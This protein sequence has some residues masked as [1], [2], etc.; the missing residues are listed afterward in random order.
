MMVAPFRFD[1]RTDRIFFCS[2]VLLL[3]ATLMTLFLPSA[4]I[5]AGETNHRLIP[6]YVAV[7]TNLIHIARDYCRDGNDWKEIARI[8]KL[9]EPYLIYHNSNIQVPLSMLVTEPLS[10]RVA[11]VN[12]SVSLLG[13][14]EQTIP[15]RKD[16]TLAAGQTVIS[17]PDGYTH[18]ILPDNTYT[19]IEPD[20]RFTINYLF[21]LPDGN[22]KTDF[23]LKKGNIV[24]WMRQKLR[25]NDSFQT[26]TPIAVTGIRGTEY[27]LK[28]DDS[29]AN[30]V[31]TLSGVVQVS[32]ASRTIALEAGKGTRVRKGAPPE[33]PRLLPDPPEGILIERL[34]RTL[35]IQI[36]A[37]ARGKAKTIHLRITTDEQGQQTVFAQN[38]APGGTF[39]IFTLPDAAYFAFVTAFDA[40]GFESPPTAPLP[41]T[42]RTSPPAP[43]VISPKKD[44]ILWGKRGQIEWLGSNQAKQYTIQLAADPDFKNILDQQQVT[45]PRYLTPELQ[46]GRY[47]V[48]V[49]AVA[50][51]GYTTLFSMPVSWKQTEEPAMK[52][53]EATANNKPSLQ[54][55]VMAEGLSYDLQVAGDEQFTQ[56]IVD[57]KGLLDTTYTMEQKLDSGTYFLRLR[58]VANGEP[59]SP[60]TPTQTLNVKRKPLGWE[61]VLIGVAVIGIIIL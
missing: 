12:G 39:S 53:M 42:I 9:S 56:L 34:Y 40:E 19:R 25:P 32:A 11:T 59:Q 47:H 33:K 57:Q 8:N 16:D 30:S 58:G 35:P 5:M 41:L 50:G 26:R 27:R 14:G 45:E 23:E 37:P 38:A 22:I 28:T 29:G 46:P 44:G 18:L 24:H 15:L 10:A 60:W 49:Q 51:D 4:G 43:I 36:K 21:R 61:E 54:W 6:L 31:E 13:E 55:P 48:R 1:R 52:G 7:D 2:K 20:S 17:G 3:M